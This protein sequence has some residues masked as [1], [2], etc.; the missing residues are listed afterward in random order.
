MFRTSD[1]KQR[2]V[3]SIHDGKRLGYINDLDIDM[4][5]G[6]VRAVIIP[7]P[8][9][10]FGLFGRESDYV[11]PWE[12]V[13]KIGID[14]VLVEANPTVPR[15]SRA[16]REQG[17]EKNP[18]LEP[19]SRER[20]GSGDFG[21][22]RGSESKA[23]GVRGEGSRSLDSSIPDNKGQTRREERPYAGGMRTFFTRD[24]EEEGEET[25]NI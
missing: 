13:V 20:D 4:E 16:W 23:R 5:T 19:G 8:G 22:F 2:D 6:K 11:I 14:V 24:E 18:P 1:L 7:G 12:Q 21:K 15:S 9:K 17:G 25:E 3:I 10:I